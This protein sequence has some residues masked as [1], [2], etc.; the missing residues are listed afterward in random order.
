MAASIPADRLTV[1]A[2]PPPQGSICDDELED[3][4]P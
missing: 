2:L 3:M 1:A 4:V